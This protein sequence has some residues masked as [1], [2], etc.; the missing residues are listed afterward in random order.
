MDISYLI[1]FAG[2][3]AAKMAYA[4]A[5]HL[6]RTA[7]L[8]YISQQTYKHITIDGEWVLQHCGEPVD[9]DGLESSWTTQIDLAQSGQTISGT[10]T[11]AC[12][13]GTSEGKQVT[14]KLKGWFSNSVL[15][16]SFI[17]QEVSSRNRSTFLL[18]VVGDGGILHGYRLFL[19]RNKNEIRAIACK[20]VRRER[21]EAASGSLSGCGTA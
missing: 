14:Y 6:S 13:H 16:I 2:G 1:T 3:V 10:A 19:G 18:Q 20:W 17:E 21:L 7:V 11:A 9:G 5:A 15:D 12:S 4:G 8:P